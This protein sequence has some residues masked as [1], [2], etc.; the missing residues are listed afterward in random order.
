LPPARAF[1]QQFGHAACIITA[2]SRTAVRV[3]RSDDDIRRAVMKK[4]GIGRTFSR[5]APAAAAA[6]LALGAMSAN[7]ATTTGTLTVT[8]AVAAVCNVG[9]ATLAFGTYN[10]GGGAV[11]Q[12]TTIAVRCTRLTPFTV[13]LNGGGSGNIS[14]RQM[15]STGTP[16]EKLDYQL[17]SDAG[18]L[19]VWGNSAGTWQSGTGAGM[20]VGNA[21]N[22]TVY[23]QVPDSVANQA[24]AALADFTDSVTITVTY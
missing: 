20:G 5:I 18:R 10:P 14:A 17:Y 11:N 15:S 4:L 1:R 9:N 7:A 3:E 19:T 13:G 22:F 2:V 12:T 21:V 24:A 8:A 6:M 23:G 16:A